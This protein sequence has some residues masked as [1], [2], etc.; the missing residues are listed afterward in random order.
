MGLN[1]VELWADLNKK[2]KNLSGSIDPTLPGKVA[3]IEEVIPSGASSEN[4]LAT[5]GDINRIDLSIEQLSG[6]VLDIQAVIPDNASSNN[7]LATADDVKMV[8]AIRMNHLKDYDLTGKTPTHVVNGD[9]SK[10]VWELIKELIET[11]TIQVDDVIALMNNNTIVLSVRITQVGSEEILGSDCLIKPDFLGTLNST[12]VM[13]AI[14]VNTTIV[15]VNDVGISEEKVE[16]T[17]SDTHINVRVTSY[18][19]IT[20][21]ATMQV[22]LYKNI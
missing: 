2:I 1:V 22:Q 17:T 14:A 6:S 5:A 11:Y 3:D 20:G 12:L 16:F 7:K 21:P 19:N 4:Q 9:G 13:T 8:N 10:K 15:D 18:S